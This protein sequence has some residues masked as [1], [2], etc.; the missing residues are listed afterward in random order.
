M[1]AAAWS[2]VFSALVIAFLHTVVGPDHTLPFVMLSRARR[3]SFSK[4]ML[5]TTVCGI[6]HVG[7][8][9]LLGLFGIGMGWGIG[10]LEGAETGRGPWAAWALVFFGFAYLLWGVRQALRRRRG[11]EIHSHGGHIHLHHHGTAHHHHLPDESEDR[12]TFWVLF[13]IFVLGPCEPLIPLFM[14]PA[15]RG[16]WGLALWTGA[17]FSAVTIFTML[18]LVGCAYLGIRRLRLG[19]LERWAE[20]LAGGVIAASG[21]AVL[22]LG[23]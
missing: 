17:A 15:S 19:P 2:L 12:S 16:D 6:G 18:T 21:L 20:A 8:S 14:L 22:F 13:V 3:W 9:L 5:I 4:T 1:D 7:S 23:L 10:R 11:I